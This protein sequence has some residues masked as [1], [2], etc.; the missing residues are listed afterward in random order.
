MLLL[1]QAG[2]ALS[3]DLHERYHHGCHSADAGH[4]CGEVAPLDLT[5]QREYGSTLVG[6]SLGIG[7]WAPG[8]STR[9]GGCRHEVGSERASQVL[10][11]GNY[12]LGGY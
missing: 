7:G 12:L 6:K 9:A 3:V 2:P 4:P 8:L 10:I 11:R 5:D 1:N